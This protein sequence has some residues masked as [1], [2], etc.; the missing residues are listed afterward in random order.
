MGLREVYNRAFLKTCAEMEAEGKTIPGWAVEKVNRLQLQMAAAELGELKQA[1]GSFTIPNPRSY[2]KEVIEAARKIAD[3]IGDPRAA[4]E[5]YSAMIKHSTRTAHL[6]TATKLVA[7]SVFEEAYP[8][9]KG[10]D[11]ALLFEEIAM[12]H[13]MHFYFKNFENGET[14]APDNISQARYNPWGTTFK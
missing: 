14:W 5:C 9:K 6:M 4:Y 7:R 1:S 13:L 8:D 10:S 12:K 11:E 2:D 3:A